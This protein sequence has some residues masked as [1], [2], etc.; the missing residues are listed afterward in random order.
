MEENLA[1]KP[2]D[3]QSRIY[4]FR[5]VQVMLDNH[6][7]ELYDVETKYL[8]KTVSRNLQRFPESFRFQLSVSEFALLRFQFGTS[9]EQGGRRYLPYVF[10]EQ[11]VAMLSAI[12][13]SET[14]IQISVQIMQAFVEMR[15]SINDNLLLQS[16]IK[17]VEKQYSVL[18]QETDQKFEEVFCALESKNELPQQGVFFEGQVFDAYVFV[19][20]L[21]RKAENQ[22]VLIDNYVD[23]SVLTLFSKKKK[24]VVCSILTKSIRKQLRLDVEKFEI[25]YGKLSLHQFS[26]SH[27]RF[28]IID[29]EEVY[30]IGASLK[31]LG[32]KWFAFSKMDKSS[33]VILQSVHK[34]INR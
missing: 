2:F 10:T 32:K 22:L 23:D 29:N 6:L 34:V 33:L 18:K 3:I 19:S 28:L 17:Q 5:G 4:T 7:A 24:H 16:Q 20:N 21:I 8:N 13:R 15:H 31:D 12:L 27:D 25:Q 14:A 9:K 11:G 1:I 30:H 26:K